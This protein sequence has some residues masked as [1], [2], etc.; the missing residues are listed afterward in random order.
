VT[1]VE[2]PGIPT[3]HVLLMGNNDTMLDNGD[4]KVNLPGDSVT[5]KCDKKNWDEENKKG[6]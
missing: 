1:L 2:D 3:V 5:M 6:D 4:Y